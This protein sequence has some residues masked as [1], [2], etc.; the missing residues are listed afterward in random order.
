MNSAVSQAT[1]N[2]STADVNALAS[3]HFD[4]AHLVRT[5]WESLIESD[6]LKQ[7][8]EYRDWVVHTYQDYFLEAEEQNQVKDKKAYKKKLSVRFDDSLM[9]SYGDE[10]S[11]ADCAS[12]DSYLQES[13]TIHLG[14]QMKQMYNIR[15]L[16]CHPLEFLRFK[17]ERY[18]IIW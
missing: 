10:D 15:L 14:S 6:K 17:N 1:Q 4:E 3:L 8:R 16:R 2:N 5:R 9:I 18:I 13:F 11:G 12:E 7:K